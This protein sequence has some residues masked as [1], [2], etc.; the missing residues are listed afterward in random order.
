MGQGQRRGQRSRSPGERVQRGQI[1]QIGGQTSCQAGEQ[2]L[3]SE[4][5]IGPSQLLALPKSE[6]ISHSIR[7]YSFLKLE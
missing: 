6:T 1:G 7:I 4:S 5:Q 2:L 3:G